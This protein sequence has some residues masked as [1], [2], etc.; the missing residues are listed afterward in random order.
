MVTLVNAKHEADLLERTRAAVPGLRERASAAVATRQVPEENFEALRRAGAL[1]TIQSQRNGGYGLS[2]RSH[3]DTVATLGEGCGS[4]SWCAGVIQAHSWLLSHF[5]VETQDEI[6]G[7]DP[8]AVVSA[9]VAPRGRAEVTL[10][11]Y[12]LTGFW[13]FASGNSGAKWILLGGTVVDENDTVIDEGQFAVP[14]DAITRHDDWHVCGLAG[15]G[16]S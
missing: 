2:M 10:D 11:G 9:V 14:T 6:Y 3:L 8:D 5:S 15:T 4:T 12:L 13:P 1:K 7:V 16:S